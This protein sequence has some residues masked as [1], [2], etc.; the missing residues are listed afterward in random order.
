MR[1][2]LNIAIER[3]SSSFVLREFSGDLIEFSSSLQLRERFFFF[4][5]LFALSKIEY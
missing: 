1:V 2:G 3:T 4:A 5:M